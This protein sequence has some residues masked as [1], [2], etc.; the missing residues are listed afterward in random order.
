MLLN[1][2]RLNLHHLDSKYY[3]LHQNCGLLPPTG[4]LIG[5][6]WNFPLPSLHGAFTLTPAPAYAHSHNRSLFQISNISLWQL[7]RTAG[8]RICTL[9][10][11]FCFATA[12]KLM[13]RGQ[14]PFGLFRVGSVV[15]SLKFSSSVD[16]LPKFL[17][18]RNI[19][20]TGG[21]R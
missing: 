10:R 7:L 6:F 20:R 11:I 16:L 8:G 18:P 13:A 2:V 17:W 9:A 19:I 1:L 21:Q 15:K 3:I 12:N 5:D 14:L 4:T